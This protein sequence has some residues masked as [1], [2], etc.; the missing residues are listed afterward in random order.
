MEESYNHKK[1]VTTTMTELLEDIYEMRQPVIANLFYAGLYIFAGP[2]KVGKSFMV[3]QI[4]Y[5]VS[6]GLPLWNLDVSRGTVLYLALED[7]KERIQQRLAKMFPLENN[8]DFYFAIE[9]QLL[10]KGL[11]KQLDT[12]VREHKNTK[13]VIIDTLQKIKGTVKDIMNYG[14]DYDVIS[15]LKKFA[16]ENNICVLVVHHTRKQESSDSFDMISGTQGLLG[17]ADGALVISKEKR[18]GNQAIL[19]ITSRDQQDLKIELE[20]DRVTCLWKV[21]KIENELWQEPVDMVLEII[22]KFVETNG[23]DWCGSATD[24]LSGISHS[25]KRENKPEYKANTLV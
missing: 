7:V 2:P 4:G 1:L 11:M 5:H 23:F 18:T 8:D 19:E 9:A 20:M 12:F 15:K 16:D 25:L 21:K 10:N 13:L 6:M 3:A 22:P 24:L 17:A 14:N